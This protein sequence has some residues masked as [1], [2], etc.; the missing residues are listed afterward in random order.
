MTHFPN[1]HVTVNNNINNVNETNHEFDHYCLL[2]AG[3]LNH[4]GTAGW[5]QHALTHYKRFAQQCKDKNIRITCK[6]IV[7]EN[8]E[9]ISG[10][11]CNRLSG[12]G[13][14]Y[15]S[16]FETVENSNDTE[17]M[18]YPWHNITDKTIDPNDKEK[19]LN[20]ESWLENNSYD[21]QLKKVEFEEYCKIVFVLMDNIQFYYVDGNKA[22][23]N[24]LQTT[25]K[26]PDIKN[27]Y[28][29]GQH[30]QVNTAYS[31][32]PDMF[33]DCDTNAI[34]IKVRYDGVYFNATEHFN[35]TNTFDIPPELFKNVFYSIDDNDV[36]RNFFLTGED[37]RRENFNIYQLPTVMY[38]RQRHDLKEHIHSFPHDI[39]LIFNKEGIVHYAKHYKDFILNRA[40]HTHDINDKKAIKTN[41]YLGF[42]IH[43]SLGDFF[44]NSFNQ[45]D[46]TPVDV[47]NR[48]VN[49][50][51]ATLREIRLPPDN[52]MYSD[53]SDD[54]KLRWYDGY[55]KI[56]SMI[57]EKFGKHD[58]T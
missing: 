50:F 57:I 55:W 15:Q 45:L 43:T 12:F 40:L 13:N 36:F 11:K 29:F 7:Y 4:F 27:V 30:F 21:F 46:Y 8:D 22:V 14:I 6:F 3:R 51:G 31:I 1:F 39:S 56:K 10:H 17:H 28:G 32:Y 24:E 53:V 52:R 9:V 38:T 47:N 58:N 49:V 23:L 44:K 42:H 25:L 26:N 16:L 54:Y 19:Y 18:F 37:L 2:F 35:F 34:V 33:N 41:Q 48:S 5:E 20:I